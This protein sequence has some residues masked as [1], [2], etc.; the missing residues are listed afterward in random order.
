MNKNRQKRLLELIP[1]GLVWLA[2]ILSVVLSFVRPLWVIYFI[3]A[4]DL[5]WFLRVAHFSILLFFAWKLHD[6]EVKINWLEKLKTDKLPW[7]NIYHYIILPT[8][9]EPFEVLDTTLNSFVQSNYPTNKM[10]VHLAGEE[11]CKESFLANVEKIKA[12]YEKVFFHLIISLHPDGLEGEMKGKGANA[13]YGGNEGKKEIDRLGLKYEDIICS[14][15]DSD[16]C[17]HPEYFA[18]LTYKYLTV[19]DPLHKA[20]QPAVVYNNNIWEA[21]AITRI[22]AFGTVFWLMAELIRP[23]RMYTFSSHAMPYKA[24]V[25]IGFW[26][27]DIVTDDSR[28]FL[29]GFFR[30]NGQFKVEPIYIPVSMDSV[31]ADSLW[32]SAR[33]LYKQQRRWAWGVEHFPYM[34]QQ[35]QEHPEISWLKKFK[36]TFNLMEGMFSW[37][38]APILIFILGRLPLFIAGLGA[39]SSSVLVQNTPFVL[40]WIMTLSMLGLFVSAFFSFLVLPS[41][42]KH[43]PKNKWLI[44]VLQWALLPFTLIIFGA[45]PAIEAQTRLMLGK[46][47]HLGFWVTPKP[48]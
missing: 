20:Y 31:M 8:S 46:K 42:P 43:A 47:Y 45:I 36:Y 1:G 27:K 13:H 18:N 26:Q 17:V 34:M 19:E 9:I 15:F 29:Q 38:L 30:Y 37:A 44:M 28:I 10:I 3:I 23:E 16:T 11:R 5:L 7:E 24:L 41:R 12:K 2:L 14:Y 32:Q 33:N 48:R 35:F 21:P 6:N 4:Y 39:Q 40:E 25:D 22:T